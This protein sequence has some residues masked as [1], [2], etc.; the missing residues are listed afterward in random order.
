MGPNGREITVEKRKWDGTIS[1][2][3]TGARLVRNEPVG[4]VWLLPV[5]AVRERPSR[6]HREEVRTP[7]AWAGGVGWWVVRAI[8]APDGGVARILIDAAVPATVD[9]A[10]IV[11][12]DLDIDLEMTASGNLLKDVDQF[13]ERAARMGYPDHVRRSAWRGLEDAAERAAQALWPFDGTLEALLT[14]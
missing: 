10:G 5:G 2:I 12:I 9:A 13:R 4:V 6:G 11:F 3:W 7:E 8:G 1:S 14:P